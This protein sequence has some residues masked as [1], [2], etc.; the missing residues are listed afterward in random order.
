MQTNNLYLHCFNKIIQVGP[1]T[2]AL[3]IQ[4]FPSIKKAF[5]TANFNDYLKIGLK[6]KIAQAILSKKDDISPTKEKEYF[7]KNDITLLSLLDKKYPARLREISSPPALLYIRGD[8]DIL[9]GE[10]LISFVGSRK[11]SE[12][13]K[14]ATEKTIDDLANPSIVI[15]SGLAIGCDALAHKSALA[16]NLKTIAVVGSG[17]SDEVLYPQINLNLAHE[18]IKSGGAVI[19]EYPPIEKA[20]IHYFPMRNR[21]ISGLSLGVVVI[22]AAKRSGALITAYS[23]VDQNREVLAIPGNVFCASHVGCNKLIQKGAKLVITGQDILDELCLD[24]ETKFRL[25]QLE[26]KLSSEEE[27]ILAAIKNGSQEIGQIIKETKLSIEKINSSLLNLEINNIINKIG[28][29]T[30]ITL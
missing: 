9:D 7:S 15:V 16:N 21:I 20:R 10:N 13:G 26:Q 28:N 17:I 30:Y 8:T 23:A 2:L 22:E 19:S 11:I 6:P 12:Y 5:E 25:D 27:I 29:Q 18:I 1:K 3:I 4:N 14:I 24:L